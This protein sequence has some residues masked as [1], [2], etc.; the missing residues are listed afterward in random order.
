MMQLGILFLVGCI[1]SY[2][3]ISL[4]MQYKIL[5]FKKEWRNEVRLNR[6]PRHPATSATIGIL[7]AC[8]GCMCGYTRSCMRGCMC[9]G[10]RG[11]VCGGVRGCRC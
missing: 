2:M 6:H 11:C 3:T 7:D 8:S 1:C 9:G 5:I 4:H 10:V